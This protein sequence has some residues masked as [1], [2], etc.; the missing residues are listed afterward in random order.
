MEFYESMLDRIADV[1]LSLCTHPNSGPK[2]I[3]P[4]ENLAVDTSRTM[5]E[6]DP[7]FCHTFSS[8]E[9]GKRTRPAPSCYAPLK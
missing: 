9:N 1:D 4:V 2:L 7:Q 3:L 8:G 6:D 5:F